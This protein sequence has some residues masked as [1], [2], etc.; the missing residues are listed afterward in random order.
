[1]ITKELFLK[2]TKI[3]FSSPLNKSET[4]YKKIAGRKIKLNN[5]DYIQFEMVFDNKIYHENVAVEKLS[6]YFDDKIKLYKQADL[7]F[8]D[9]GHY[10]A[11]NQNNSLVYHKVKDKKSSINTNTSH[12]KEKNYIIN[13]GDNIPI[14]IELGVFTKDFKVINSMYAKF[15]QINRFIELF[16]DV[17][18]KKYADYNN[19]TINIIDFG[20]GKSYLTFIMYYYLTVIKKFNVNMTGIDLKQDVIKKCNEL[21][22]KYKYKNLSFT[23]GDINGYKPPFTP[24]VVISL[25]GCDL[26]T[27][28]A[29]YNALNWQAEVIFVA[30]CCE[31]EINSQIDIAPLRNILKYG[32]VKERFSALLTNSIRC[33][34][35]EINDYK[36]ELIEFVDIA[37]SPKNL[38]IRAVKSSH[39]KSYKDGI[40]KELD[41][42]LK[43]FNVSQTLYDLMCREK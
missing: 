11:F 23:V 18:S 22:D 15:K 20:C 43:Q 9:G 33:N 42:A 10:I 28:Y 21:R 17:I 38:L 13:E 19:N 27:D 37:H 30:P 3:I 25:H 8:D 41:E 34:I 4:K 31:H 6:D 16:D 24:D 26:A 35:L 2:T 7:Y 1:M 40:K 5:R 36:T 29:L 39:I 12:N 14:L 32:I